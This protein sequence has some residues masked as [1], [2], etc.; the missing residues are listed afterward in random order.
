MISTIVPVYN[1]EE[2]L[3]DCITSILE[4]SYQDIEL[5]LVDDGSTDGS[6][7][8]CENFAAE[9]ARV[10]VIR[11]ENGG[12]STARN[13]G[14]DAARG[15]F[16]QFVDA[17][18]LLPDGSTQRLVDG[19]QGFGS[20]YTALGSTWIDLRTGRRQEFTLEESVGLSFEEFFADFARW[21]ALEYTP[22][23]CGKL[24]RRSILEG[25]GIRF[26]EGVRIG[27]DVLFNK[28]FFEHCERFALLAGVGY[29]YLHHRAG[30]SASKTTRFEFGDDARAL[31]AARRRWIASS[32]T[33]TQ[34]RSRSEEYAA[35]I[36][37]HLVPLGAQRCSMREFNALA[38]ELR[39]DEIYQ[40][41]REAVPTAGLGQSV[42]GQLFNHGLFVPLYLLLR[43]AGPVQRF[44]HRA[45]STRFFH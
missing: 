3:A 24:Y 21:A 15:H 22:G 1:A 6:A 8:L 10:S 27:E 37:T 2:T 18:D 35:H 25:H 30:D 32:T 26:P 39:L 29:L 36:A 16:V 44:R 12:V 43:G 17:D 42:R 34:R 20:D 13:A 11:K 38:R 33:E 4:Q 7:A 9:D 31:L 45:S 19:Q 23:P 28:M 41:H 14:L 5:I 40:Q